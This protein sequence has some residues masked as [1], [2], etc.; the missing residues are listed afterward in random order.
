MLLIIAGF[1]MG[2]GEAFWIGA[3]NLDGG[4][5]HNDDG[6]F[7]NTSLPSLKL[8]YNDGKG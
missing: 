5:W 8:D 3:N 7:F 6:S 1:R 4:V 2:P